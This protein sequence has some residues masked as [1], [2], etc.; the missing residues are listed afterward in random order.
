MLRQSRLRPSGTGR[1]E[2]VQPT[3]VLQRLPRVPEQRENLTPHRLKQQLPGR[4]RH[5]VRITRR[6]AHTI[7]L[8]SAWKE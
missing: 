7:L 3:R 6:R 8:F 5:S 1:P 2:T 4:A